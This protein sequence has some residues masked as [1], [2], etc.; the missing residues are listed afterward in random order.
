MTKEQELEIIRVCGLNYE[1]ND[2]PP[3]LRKELEKE[4]EEEHIRES[5]RSED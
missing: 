4:I 3:A 2:I 1:Y 5:A